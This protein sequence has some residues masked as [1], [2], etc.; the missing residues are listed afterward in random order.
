MIR[1]PPRSTLFPYTTLFRSKPVHCK[2]LAA[3][4]TRAMLT[5]RKLIQAKL[6]DVEMSLR[7]ILRGFGLKVGKTTAR[8]FAAR[9][10]ELTAGHPN[11]ET[12]ARALLAVGAVLLR[13]VNGFGEGVR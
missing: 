3:Q 2:S 7:G 12:I 11:L 4:E 9:I 8:S 10:E 6:H 13:E 5:A 1:R